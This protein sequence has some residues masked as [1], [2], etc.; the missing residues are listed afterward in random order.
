MLPMD[1]ADFAEP[2]ELDPDDQPTAEDKGEPA[3]ADDL[4]TAE[5]T[6]GDFDADLLSPGDEGTEGAPE[7]GAL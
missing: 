5:A 2:S 4:Y 7:D 6:P 3:E 1:P